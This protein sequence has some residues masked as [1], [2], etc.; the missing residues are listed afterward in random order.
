MAQNS[1]D[2]Y[3]FALLYG[4]KSYFEQ[5]DYKNAIPLFEYVISN[6]TKFASDDYK[7][8]ALSLALSYNFI[9]DAK[10][11]KK[12]VNLVSSL[13]KASFDSERRGL[14]KTWPEQRGGRGF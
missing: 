2:Y 7:D 13:E 10:N 4:G 6:G 5:A 11:A 12:C 14:Q 9:G 3:S 1:S 8:C